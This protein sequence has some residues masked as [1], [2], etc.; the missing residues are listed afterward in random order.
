MLSSQ[1][2]DKKITDKE[3]E[4]YAI[5]KKIKVNDKNKLIIKNEIMQNKYNKQSIK[6]IGELKKMYFI[7]IKG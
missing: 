1:V 3:I 2:K 4:N 7:D 6:M 5:E